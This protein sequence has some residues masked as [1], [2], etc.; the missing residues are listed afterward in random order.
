[1]GGG[2]G[3]GLLWVRGGG[4]GGQGSMWLPPPPSPHPP[5]SAPIG[6]QYIILLTGLVR[7]TPTCTSQSEDALL[8]PPHIRLSYFHTQQQQLLINIQQQ[9][10]MQLYLPVYSIKLLFY[11]FTLKTKGYVPGI[12]QCT[13]LELLSLN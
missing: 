11:S 6:Q 8:G 4:G 10:G 2:G 1:M 12:V 13:L 7:T 5:T 3:E 9:F